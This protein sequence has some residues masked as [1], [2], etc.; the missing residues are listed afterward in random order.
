MIWKFKLFYANYAI[1]KNYDFFFETN[2]LFKIK[3]KFK[4]FKFFQVS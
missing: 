4:I 1:I 2:K 3:Q